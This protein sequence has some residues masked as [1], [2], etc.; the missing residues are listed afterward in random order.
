MEFSNLLNSKILSYLFFFNI[1]VCFTF[2]FFFLKIKIK[3][4]FFSKTSEHSYHKGK[5]FNNSG[6][7]IVSLFIFSMVVVY[8][9]EKSFDNLFSV[10][11][12][13]YYL[14]IL[15]VSLLFLVSII[16]DLFKIN[17][18]IRLVLQITICYL[19]LPIFKFPI[20]DLLPEKLELLFIVYFFVLIINTNNFIDGSD[21]VMGICSLVLYTGV[22]IISYLNNEIY[23]ITL[24]SLIMLSLIIPFLFFNWPKAKTFLGDTGSIPVG[25]INGYIIIFLIQI[26]YYFLGIILF[27]YPLVDVNLTLIRKTLSGIPPWARLFDYYF[28]A[29]TYIAGKD[30]SY[31]LLRIILIGITNLFFGIVYFSTSNLIIALAS[32]VPNFYLIYLF[33]KFRK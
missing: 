4:S 6:V 5:I 27:L 3:H 23:P 12:S 29:P 10:F 21:G 14:L 30:H 13:R 22:L 31:V 24:I 15:S 26:D 16:D 33:N 25:F 1:L 9:Y 18:T 19:S 7:I 2:I 32:L 28:L 11:S 20:I 8:L 17:P